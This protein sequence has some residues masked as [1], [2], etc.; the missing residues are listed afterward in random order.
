MND[1]QEVY[2]ALSVLALQCTIPGFT[3]V[4]SEDRQKRSA[5]LFRSGDK[6]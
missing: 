6:N 4:K 3:S 2:K 5:R 1:K